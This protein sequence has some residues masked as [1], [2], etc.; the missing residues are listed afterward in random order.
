[1]IYMLIF[2]SNYFVTNNRIHE[3]DTRQ[4]RNLHFEF[5]RMKLRASSLR[6]AGPKFWNTIP[7]ETHNATSLFTFKSR[8]KSLLL[9]RSQWCHSFMSR[10]NMCVCACAHDSSYTYIYT[11]IH[12]CKY[13]HSVFSNFYYQLVTNNQAIL[14][15]T[16]IFLTL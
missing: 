13:L 4:A 1:M 8:V 5:A 14:A 3:H 9:F 7:L 15:R 10:C 16:K 11:S 6:I 12:I 2:F